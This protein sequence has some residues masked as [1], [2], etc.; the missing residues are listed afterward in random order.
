MKTI[1]ISCIISFILGYRLKAW[2]E[3]KNLDKL[4]KE[5]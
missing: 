2:D 1:I 4:L 5:K 3:L